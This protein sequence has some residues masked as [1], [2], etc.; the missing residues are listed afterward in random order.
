MRRRTAVATGLTFVAVLG[1]CAG[2]GTAPESST[3]GTE[4]GSGSGSGPGTPTPDGDTTPTPTSNASATPVSTPGNDY[5]TT[6]VDLVDA[7][8]T[9]LATVDAWIADSYPKRYT[10]LSDTSALENGQGMLFVHDQEGTHAYVMR[11]MAFPLDMV[12]IAANGTITTIHH[13]PL[14]SEDSDGGLTRYSGR[15]KYVL[16]VPMGYTNETGVEVGD[17]VV[18]ENA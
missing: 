11:E 14:P 17:R 1:G 4:T 3:T 18:I 16:E 15:A 12:F 13:A 7:D 6:T 10:G 9:R 2:L 8:G 5:E